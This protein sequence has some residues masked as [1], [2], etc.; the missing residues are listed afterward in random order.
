[1]ATYYWVGGAGTW[2]TASNTNWAISSGG[3]GGLVG[4]PT[5]A[6]D[7]IIDTSSGTGVI[8]CTGAVCRDITVTA[9]QAITLGAATSTLSI[10]NNLTFPSGGS[11]AVN[12]GSGNVITLAATATGKT[13]TTN[14]KSIGNLTINGVGGGW[15]LGSALTTATILLTTGTFNANGFNVTCNYLNCP[16]ASTRTLT[17]GNGLWTLTGTGTV[18]N[19]GTINLT[20]NK[21]TSNILLSDT[22]TSSRTLFASTL[23]YNK[24]TIGGATG[25]S[26]TQFN[27]SPTIGELASTKTVAHTINFAV[28]PT[29]TTWSVTG[30]AG[31]LVSV[32][33]SAAGTRRTINITNVTSGIDYLSVKDIGVSTTNK[34]YVGVNSTDGGNNL[35]VYFTATPTATANGNFFFMMGM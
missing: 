11:F 15:T 6:D 29:I 3:T 34:F 7:A 18:W 9:T 31:N 27:N 20:F 21:G 17:L 24:I 8:T 10:F 5:S 26:T 2:N 16:N 22:S 25:T 4:P 35:N 30:T 19:I 14:G 12:T 13:V 33:S 32:G 23:T 1:M 28:S